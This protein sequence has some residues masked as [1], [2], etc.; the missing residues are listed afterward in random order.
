MREIKFRAWAKE[1]KEMSEIF[2]FNEHVDVNDNFEDDTELM[3]MQYTGLKDKNGV[4][5]YEG[6]MLV[7]DYDE[8]TRPFYGIIKYDD[9]ESIFAGGFTLVC[10][11][12]FATDYAFEDS[13]KPSEWKYLEVIGNIYENPELME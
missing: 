3:Y 5:I 9:S 1:A 8:E 6:D 12:G 4:E 11:D 2:Y 10:K 7:F 13:G